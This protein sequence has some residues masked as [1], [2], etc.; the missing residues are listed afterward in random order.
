M[1]TDALADGFDEL[2]WIDSDIGFDPDAVDLLRSH[3]LALVSGIYPKKGLRELACSLMPDTERIDFG[4]AGGL[5]EIRYAAAGFLYTRRELYE[6][7]A[8][9]EGLPVCNRRFGR[10]TVPYFLP[11]LLPQG[12][13][14]HWYLGED[15]AFCERARRSGFGVFADTRIRLE[16]IGRHGYTWEDAGSTRDRFATYTFYVT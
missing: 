6:K 10:G 5:L 2:M 7:M 11:L 1:A 3:D 14:D 8:V 4:E 15:Y 13:R 12:K 9:H 16:H